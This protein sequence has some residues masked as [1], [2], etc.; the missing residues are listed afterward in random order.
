[1][2]LPDIPC[3]TCDH[4]NGAIGNFIFL[5]SYD[6][7]LLNINCRLYVYGY[8]HILVIGVMW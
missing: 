7:F 4:P 6:V 3:E 1:M 5:K 2:K 8:L